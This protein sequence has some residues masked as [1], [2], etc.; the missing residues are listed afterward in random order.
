[1]VRQEHIEKLKAQS[2]SQG[3]IISFLLDYSLTSLNSLWLSVQSKLP[4]NIFNFNVRYLNNTLAN[5]ANLHKWKL[6]PSPDR[7]FCLHPESLLH[8]V[9]GCK[10]YLEDCRYTWKY[11]SALH[12]IALSLQ[13]L[14]QS[15]LYVDL[16]GFTSPCIVSGDHLHPDMLLSIDTLYIIDLTVEFKTNIDLDAERKYD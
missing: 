5:H 1:M 11:N 7:S 15:T 4:K 13:C 10:S 12:F 16:P 2:P 6:P 8:I 14:K 3:F 9:A